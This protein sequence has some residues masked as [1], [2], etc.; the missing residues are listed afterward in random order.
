MDKKPLNKR[1]VNSLLK[2]FLSKKQKE[3]DCKNPTR[4]LIVRQHNQFGDMMAT[5]PLFRAI[6]KKFPEA[7][8]TV[9]ASNENAFGISSAPYID[10]LF[11]F[12]KTKLFDFQYL[13]IFH[14][15]LRKNKY[16]L[17]IIPS[18]VSL[19]F[20]SHLIGALA[21]SDFVI[22]ASSLDGKENEASYML[23]KAVELT[24]QPP[25][26]HVS[27]F[28]IDVVRPIGINEN[29]FSTELNLTE[30]NFLFATEFF[31]KFN[32][33]CEVKIGFHVGA[34]KPPNRWSLNNFKELINRLRKIPNL[35]FYFTGSTADEK[36]I[37]FM[38]KAFGKDAGYLLNKPIPDVAA[39]I[40]TSDLF[41]TND[42]GIMHVA[43]ATSVPQ[44]SLF[45]PT[46][47][48]QWAPVGEYKYFVK[49]ADEINS[50][51]V[52]EIYSL[53][54]K[55]LYNKFVDIN[56]NEEANERTN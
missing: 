36:E 34:G 5:I 13:R 25:N 55:L 33:D 1:I 30:E 39:V 42:T 2:L 17:V 9:L 4:I 21:K 49:K 16:N 37:V 19:S 28:I 44:V 20:T 6:K 15:V 7:Q 3:F 23:N 8:L 46:N 14:S 22:G 11:I 26:R 54:L 10:E 52:D 40:A 56:K 45:G 29:D 31:K 12:D 48:L 32:K 43:G 50:I 51:T 27:D 18:T 35:C 47:P 38:I 24:W 53:S 41:V